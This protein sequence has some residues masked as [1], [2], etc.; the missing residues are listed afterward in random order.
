MGV[1]Q[2][3]DFAW[4][5]LGRLLD[6]EE[7]GWQ[8][9]VGVLARLLAATCAD[10][11]HRTLD[12]LLDRFQA[13]HELAILWLHE[14]Y[15]VELRAVAGPSSPAGVGGLV[16]SGKG[17]G[18]YN[19]ALKSLL[20]RLLEGGEEGLRT[21]PRLLAE[22]PAID[23]AVLELVAGACDGGDDKLSRH[24]GLS[25]LLAVAVHHPNW[26]DM[27]MGRLLAFAVATDD[28]MRSAAVK[29]VATKLFHLPF[30]APRI[31]EFAV[32]NLRIACGLAAAGAVSAVDG[33]EVVAAP[34][35]EEVAGARAHQL[36]L[37]LS[38]VPHRH[39]MLDD[40]V[41]VYVEAGS[42]ARLALQAAIGGMVRLV[43]AGSA[44]LQR[45]ISSQAGG[46][47][48]AEELVLAM[49]RD[50]AEHAAP[51]P[52]LLVAVREAYSNTK[53]ARL[54]VY[55]CHAM[56]KDQVEESLGRVVALPSATVAVALHRLLHARPPP[57]APE[58]LVAALHR[59]S[60]TKEL[61]L[62]RLAEAVELCLGERDVF[63]TQV[64]AVVL[65]RVSEQ[66]PLPVLCM[67]TVLL[68][69]RLCPDLAPFVLG[70]ILQR[71][72]A[73]Q[74]WKQPP[75]WEG[76]LRCCKQ[77][78]PRSVEALLTLPPAQLSDAIQACP[79]LWRPLAAHLASLQARGVSV[80]S[81]YTAVIT[82]AAPHKAADAAP[83][84]ADGR[85]DDR[86]GASGDGRDGAEAGNEAR[87]GRDGLSRPDAD[88]RDRREGDARD[89]R[90]GRPG[91]DGAEPT[92]QG[93]DPRD[94]RR[95][96]RGVG[97]GGREGRGGRGR[98][99]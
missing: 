91:R 21:V 56:T 26:R 16:Y 10:A 18:R 36:H 9:R 52:A 95:D 92:R 57:L 27:C 84:S 81:H 58:Q 77:T 24:V 97:G 67:R 94:S 55:V 60:P 79:E 38:L 85:K 70:T 73:R 61:S 96:S 47:K 33:G 19:V 62:R 23:A 1:D 25:S 30:V 68:C 87:D 66:S 76:F 63:P 46:L 69:L 5:A 86:R 50:L 4:E 15:A 40:L 80:S 42:A 45:I 37:F 7:A 51:A 64:L 39:D 71:L 31:R 2:V 41:Q 34:A 74:V 54:M 59:L 98:N 48:E 28:S 32:G 29:L 12:H 99:R 43:G 22:A 65:Q 83:A 90:D 78:L 17:G 44:Q 13:R 20:L 82:K 3:R 8:A 75:L 53:D 6:G 89:R 35:G 93:R 14:L 49:I 88:M 11:V 72:V